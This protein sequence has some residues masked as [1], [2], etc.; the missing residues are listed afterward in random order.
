MNVPY[1]LYRTS[2]IGQALADSLDDLIKQ[3]HITPQLAMKVLT[4]FDKSITEALETKV[5]NKATF[6][7][8]H[9]HTYRFCDEVWTFI[10]EKPNFRVDNNNEQ[11]HVEKIKIVACNAKKPG[12]YLVNQTESLGISSFTPVDWDLLIGFIKLIFVVVV[13][14]AFF[15]PFPLYLSPVISSDIPLFVAIE[16][17]GF[18][19][20]GS[21]FVS[22]GLGTRSGVKNKRSVGPQSRGASYKKLKKPVVVG[23]LV[24]SFAGVLNVMDESGDRLNIERSWA[25][26]VNSEVDSVSGVLDLDNL[27][28]I[29]AEETS[30]A[31]SDAGLDDNMNNAM[32][33]K[34]HTCTYVLNSKPPPLSFNILSDGKDTLPLSSLKFCGSNR[35]PP[36][37]LRAPEKQ[38]FNLSKS[39][40]LDIELSAVPG[41]T[42]GD[43]LVSIKKIFYCVDGFGRAS[44][45]SKFPR[46]I[47]SSFTSEISLNKAREMAIGE[48]ILVNNDLRK[49]NSRSDWEV[50]VKEI[51]VDLSKL[52]I[53][54]VFSRFGKIVSIKVQL[55]GL[56]Q[57]A[58]VEYKS[59]EIADLHR[60]LLYTLPVGTNVHDLSNLLESYGGK[61]CYI[62]RNPSLYVHDRC[63]IICF[64]D[65]ASKLAAIAGLSLASCACCKQFGHV[66]VNCSLGVYSGVR[67]RRVVSEQD[68]VRLAG[69]YKKKSAPV[70][71]PV[72][73]GEKTWAQVAGS[74]PSR[75][76]S[77]GAPG[78]SLVSGLMAFS[79]DSSLSGAADLGGRLAVLEHSIE[80]LSDQVSLILKKLSFV[81]LVP[82]ASFPS[83]L[84]LVSPT[85]VVSDMDLGLELDG[86]LL[87]SASSSPNVGGSVVDFSPSSSKILTAK[88]GSLELN[89]MA[90]EASIR[91]VLDR[92]DHLRSGSGNMVSFI[93]ETKLR[94]SSGPWIKDKFDGVRVFSSGLDK[95]FM[96]ARVAIVMNTSLAR[97][98]FKVE[99]IPGRVI[100]V[101]LL[102]KGKLSVTVL[103][104]YA[105]ASSGARFGQASEVNT[106]IVKMVNSSNFVVLGGD[107]N[108]NRSGRSV[109]FK[110]CL[111]LGLVNL[112]VGHHL[113]NSYTWSNSRGVGKTIDYI[114]VGGNLSS[115]VAGHQVVSVSDFF[116]TDHKA[117]VVSVGLG[118]LLDVQLN[119]LRKQ[120][121]K[122]CW[123]FKIRNADCVGWAK[124]KDLSS[125]KLL[126]LGEVFSGA[127]IHGDVDA[128][129]T[130][131]VEAVVD[132]ADVTFSRHWFSK[133]KCSRNKHSSRFFGLELLVAKIVKKFCSGDL[134]GTDRLVSKWLTLNDAKA[135][136]FKDL[137]GSG[138]KSDVVVRHLSLVCRDYRRSKMFESKLAEEALVRKA[139]EKCMDNFCSDKGSMIRSVL[140]KPFCKVVLDHLIVDN[141]L[142][143]LPEEVK[144]NVD[145]I[146]E[147]WTRK[148]SVQSV[149]P[150]LWAHQ[151]APLD[152]V[153]DD[154]FSG[155]MSA[156]SMGELLSVVGGL[157][158][159]KAA[160][161]SGV[162][163][164]L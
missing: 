144:S 134:L 111:S 77:S 124:F 120:A 40:A 7:G 79:M 157:L 112:F 10:I 8:G 122:D 128:M 54:A 42:N 59:S 82:L 39:F 149:L 53:E 127:K 56:W 95:G 1:E 37:R 109:S 28:N 29:V 147:G 150:D 44:T 51:P 98:V 137:V 87:L 32:L 139:I 131:L 26:E 23:G 132:S 152:Y 30:Y 24:E 156:I 136:A 96:G 13:E 103:G 92:L 38:S 88:I 68:R 130:V 65:E 52:A 33:R 76:V 138:V 81:D 116:D 83:A 46:I 45:P 97:H 121:N 20:G 93:T 153:R 154:A 94:F 35:L 69:I 91:S 66:S 162:P 119:S 126:S 55:I 125:A 21:G 3:G 160:G 62:G 105:G 89:M 18:A 70:A 135:R 48:K 113:A 49:V 117:V 99:E 67:R 71:C 50:I 104:L 22:A 43:K 78:V 75:I 115:A 107:L 163:N 61:T 148:R 101:R 140:E 141:N 14:I 159:G 57:K 41:K 64:G 118:G 146:M 47:R 86:M 143:L 11:V 145:G 151:Y 31:E 2:S 106:L 58:L 102:F 15:F 80:I 12:H 74:S 164:E 133:F 114:F 4:Q 123:K 17:V 25:S 73:F 72:S 63:A 27:E 158:D 155:V 9:L 36:V 6:K 5:K 84:P 108:E 34:T 129:W 110:F 100:S 16:P 60:A 90:L 19:A 142:V 161:L 85:A